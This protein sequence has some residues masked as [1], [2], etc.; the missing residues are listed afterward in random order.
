MEQ[1]G[2]PSETAG[3][4]VQALPVAKLEIS[5]YTSLKTVLLLQCNL[6]HFDVI[7]SIPMQVFIFY[8][9]KP[10]CPRAP[11]IFHSF[12]RKHGLLELIVQK[13]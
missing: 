12:P 7:Y 5:D 3:Q 1:V 6:F 2:Q 8:A 9:V 11:Y 10:S 4:T 13:P